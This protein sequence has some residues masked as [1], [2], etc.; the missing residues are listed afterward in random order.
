MTQFQRK[1][2]LVVFGAHALVFFW[3]FVALLGFS[4]LKGC[5]KKPELVMLTTIEFGQPAPAVQTQEVRDMPEPE[6]PAPEPEPQPEPPPP[7]PERIPEKPKKTIKPKKV[8]PKPPKKVE[9]K[10]KPTPVDQIKVSDKRIEPA[11]PAISEKDLKSLKNIQQ[12]S[13]TTSQRN[14]G[15]VGDPNVDAAYASQITRFFDRKWNNPA[16]ASPT[17]SAVIR[18]YISKWGTITKVQNIQSSGD[19][20]FDNAAL[21]LVRSVKT[22]AKPPANYSYEYVEIEFRT[23]N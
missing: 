3:F 13:T 14:D 22:V 10:W 21:A 7:E 4:M 20:T 18:V 11:K 8:E 15:P 1:A 23:R 9:P 12:P 5:F 16:D 2:T 17:G 6:P 19:R